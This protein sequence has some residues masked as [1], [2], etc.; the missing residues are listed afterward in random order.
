MDSNTLVTIVVSGLLGFFMVKYFQ[1]KKEI[2]KNDLD[3]EIDMVYRSIDDVRSN[4]E[5]DVERLTNKID[6]AQ[7]EIYTEIDRKFRVFSNALNDADRRI[8]EIQY[9]NSNKEENKQPS[10]FDNVT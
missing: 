1:M 10:L 8:D 2:A 5:K 7:S 4:L 3:R 9:V 6:V